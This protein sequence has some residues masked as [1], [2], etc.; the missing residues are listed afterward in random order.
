MSVCTTVG[1]IITQS[2]TY[3]QFKDNLIPRVW[4][5]KLT[6]HQIMER[7]DGE[8]AYKQEFRQ[9]R[10]TFIDHIIRRVVSEQQ[11]DLHKMYDYV[12]LAQIYED[13]DFFVYIECCHFVP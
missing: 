3:L 6:R 4:Q 12:D 2:E 13:T 1:H 5:N 8:E 7:I 9:Y 10:V 11:A